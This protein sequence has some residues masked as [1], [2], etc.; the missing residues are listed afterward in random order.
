MD[1][2]D[3]VCLILERMAVMTRD[4]R[5]EVFASIFEEYCRDCYGEYL[6]CYCIHDD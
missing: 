4:E 2:D 1:I 6:P 5:G 3:L